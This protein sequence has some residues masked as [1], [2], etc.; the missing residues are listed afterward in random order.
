MTSGVTVSEEVKTIH[1]KMKLVKSD[2][3]EEDRIRIVVCH[4]VEEIEVEKIFR[5]KDLEDVG[6]IFKF[7][8]SLLLKDQCRY[9]LYDCHYQTKEHS[10]KEDVVLMLWAP[11]TA[12]I[13]P[14][15]KYA[16]SKVALDKT[17][18]GI[19]HNFQVNDYGDVDR[20]TFADKLG[21]DVLKLEGNPVTPGN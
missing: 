17:I 9:F 10:R 16:A 14:R 1:N 15:L 18:V 7:F 19:K 20:D 6:D 5:Q 13:K 2:D 11:D 21:K 8:Q 3:V 12:T 4:I